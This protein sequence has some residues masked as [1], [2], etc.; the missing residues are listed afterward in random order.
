[1]VRTFLAIEL[2]RKIIEA[3][4]ARQ[5]TWKSRCPG[6]KWV[7]PCNMHITLK[8]LGEIPPGKVQAVIGASSA[9]CSAHAA[10]S[11]ELRGK[12][13][14]PGPARPRVLWIGVRG[15]LQAAGRLYSDLEAR[16]EHL[17]FPREKR[18]FRP[19]VTV[20]RVRGDAPRGLM[21]D[22]LKGDLSLG[23]VPVEEVVVFQSRLSPAGP[24]YIPLA[25]L[26]LAKGMGR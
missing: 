5:G 22:F 14:F 9:C 12:G 15:D 19:H 6:I 21:K 3:L 2:P 18:P 17:G 25:R 23:P 4:E 10:F 20:A 26:A 1:M 13:A 7:K 16:L 11:L 8:F 24:L